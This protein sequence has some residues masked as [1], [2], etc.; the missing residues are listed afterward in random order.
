MR[1]LNR[2]ESGACTK[3]GTSEKKDKGHLTLGEG[4]TPLLLAEEAKTR[5]H[6]SS[7][8]KFV[9]YSERLRRRKDEMS[10]FESKH[11]VQIDVRVVQQGTPVCGH[12]GGQSQVACVICCVCVSRSRKSFVPSECRSRKRFESDH[13]RI[14]D[15]K[16]A[17]LG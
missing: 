15:T 5:V 3:P 9:A 13:V 10:S 4:Q 14:D 1:E 17:C 2:M 8:Q 11:P 7:S 12:T 16:N 6:A